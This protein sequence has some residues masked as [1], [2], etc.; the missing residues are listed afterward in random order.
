MALLIA[1]IAHVMVLVLAPVTHFVQWVVNLVLRL[2]GL[3]AQPDP[4]S[5]SVE[6]LRGTIALHAEEGGVEKHERD[7][8]G[9]ILDLAEVEVVEVMTHRKNMETI[10]AALSA[11]QILEQ[12][13]A[14]PYSRFPVWRGDPDTIIGVLHAKDLL[15]AVRQRGPKLEGADLAAL[16]R[17]PWFIPDTT[18]L[19][20]QLVAFRQQR[21]H[22]A[23]VVD[24]YGDLEGLVTLE[25]VIEEIV[26][27]ISDERDVETEGIES[28][29]D[30]SVLVSGW[31]T[32]RDLNRHFDWRLPDEEA[33][34]IAG[35]VIHEAQRIPEVGQSFAFHG[36]RFEV[37]RR[38]RNQIVLLKVTSPASEPASA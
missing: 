15:A 19:R 3:S 22:L 1:P 34:T 29:P 31:V 2:F 35:L 20:K 30:G 27:E 32:V 8:L 26:G 6:A 21:Q 9:G 4:L 25:D 10:D 24:E 28:Q 17:P 11:D 33:A 14:S 38:Q 23:L 7:M 12:V 37:L 5:S 36:F 18:P 13:V 16:C